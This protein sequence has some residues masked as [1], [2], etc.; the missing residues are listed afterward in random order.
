MDIV[1]ITMPSLMELFILTSARYAQQ[2]VTKP[3][4]ASEQTKPGPGATSILLGPLARLVIS[5]GAGILDNAVLKR[6]DFC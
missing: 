2:V 5:F 6:I 3:R 4:R 1:T